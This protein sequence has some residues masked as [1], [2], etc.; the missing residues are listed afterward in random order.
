M[1]LYE[2]TIS[3]PKTLPNGEYFTN[4]SYIYDIND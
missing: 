3:V 2:Y 1:S 4:N